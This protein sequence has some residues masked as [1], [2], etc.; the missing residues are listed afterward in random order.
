MGK[1]ADNP[2]PGSR[3]FQQTDAARFFGR[4]A[5]VRSVIDLWLTNRLTTVYGPVASGKTSLLLG[6]VYPRMPAERIALRPAGNLVAGLTYPFAALPEH[7]PY[8]LALLRSWSPGDI[9]TRLA[10]LSVSEFLHRLTGSGDQPV[11]VAIDQL[12]DVVL[13]AR[14]GAPAQWRQQFLAELGQ[15]VDDHPKLHLLLVARA[16]SAGR[17]ISAVGGGMRYE[18]T[19]LSAQQAAAAVARPAY[20]TG[21]SFTD[22]AITT[23]VTDLGTADRVEPSLLQV[24]CRTLWDELPARVTEISGSVVEQFSDPDAAL[25]ASCADVIGAVAAERRLKPRQLH[26]W[27]LRNFVTDNGER[28]GAYQGMPMT[29]D[30]PNAVPRGLV[31]GHLL[32]LEAS[33]PRC[34]RLLTDRLI[35]P[36]RLAGFAHPAVPDAAEYLAAAERDLALGELDFAW[37][38]GDRALQ[39]ARDH[40]ERA[41]AQSLL[42]N[43]SY[44]RGRTAEALPRYRE[45]A[46]LL[47]AVGDNSASVH[48]VAAVGRILLA[49]DRADAAV[50]ELRSAADRAPSDLGLQTQLALALWQLGEGPTAVGILNRVL[51]TDAG[52]VEA[53]QA[54]GEILADLGEAT[55]AMADLDRTNPG[56]P[57]VQAARGLALAELGEHMAAAEQFKH[58]VDSARRNGLVLLYAARALDL[59]GDKISARERAEQAIDANDPPLSQRQRQLAFKLAG[60]RRRLATG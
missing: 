30:L 12:D 8:T 42:A 49:E 33:G 54:R 20:P 2:Y 28:G 36:L 9:P 50:A 22:D 48:Q 3:P 16:A 25:A 55:S 37:H 24:V 59:A 27:L 10:G 56:R 14:P 31:D 29:A 7:N 47:Q 41:L 53:R 40:R 60:R 43:V 35:E 51:S 45:A 23:L 11:Y 13:D 1:I 4:E 32:S 34:Y 44:Q 46:V 15:A 52:Y 19:A 21:R 17:L 38:N 39:S 6:G 57:S 5:D 26:N 58:A 18:L